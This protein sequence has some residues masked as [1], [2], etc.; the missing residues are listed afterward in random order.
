MI[1]FTSIEK[2]N[3][4][5]ISVNDDNMIKLEC[6]T[7]C[8]FIYNKTNGFRASKLLMVISNEYLT[9][10][11]LTINGVIDYNISSVNQDD[12]LWIR[13]LF[14]ISLPVLAI[15]IYTLIILILSKRTI[16]LGSYTNRDII[17]P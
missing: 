13:I 8:Q 17:D 1:N 6:N 5:K 16:T 4:I 9:H 14:V 15:I 2:T 7:S 12:Y 11:S 10:I 3:T